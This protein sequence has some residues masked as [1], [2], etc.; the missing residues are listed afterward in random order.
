[1]ELPRKYPIYLILILIFFVSAYFVVPEAGSFI[2]GVLINMNQ[3][4]IWRSAR[5]ARSGNFA[6]YVSFLRERIPEDGRVV[7]PPEKVSNWALSNTPFMQFF[8]SPREVINCTTVECGSQFLGAEDTYLLIVGMDTF[9]GGGIQENE[10]HVRMLNDTWGVYGPEGGL[11]TGTDNNHRTIPNIFR[12]VLVP[13][14][15]FF[16]LILMG[17]VFARWIVPDYS[18]WFHIGVGYGLVIGVL[19]I[20]SYVTLLIL[21]EFPLQVLLLVYSIVLGLLFLFKI[22]PNDGNE[23]GLIWDSLLF[24]NNIWVLLFLGLSVVFFFIAVGS[25]YH[26]TDAIVLWGVKGEGIAQKG[27]TAV[28]EW[29]TNTTNYPLNIPLSIAALNKT[30]GTHLPTSKLLFPGFYLA[31][32][33]VLY[34]YLEDNLNTNLLGLGMLTFAMLPIMV[35]HARIG[36]A[37]LPLTYYLVTSGLFFSGL[38]RENIGNHTGQDQLLTAFFVVF[39]VWTRPEGVW[40]ILGISIVLILYGVIASRHSEIRKN[41]TCMVLPAILFWGFWRLTSMPF[42]VEDGAVSMVGDAFRSVSGGDFRFS[43]LLYILGYLGR[44]LINMRTWGGVGIGLV[45]GIL[46]F[47]VGKPALDEQIKTVFL[48]GMASVFLIIGMYYIFAFDTTHDISWWLN[49]G[50][51]RMIMPGMGLLWVGMMSLFSKDKG[52]NTVQKSI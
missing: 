40:F 41:L 52:R 8:L 25:G 48:S 16:Y 46:Y 18:L 6:D 2:K 44:Q 17:F 21:P 42:A 29:G 19:S 3:S 14:L 37:N 9:P 22:I 7:L 50:F 35:R 4:G 24:S 11:G 47:F 45:V 32:I 20:L 39:T 26:A 34:G 33:L 1:M 38:S 23:V 27:L 5:F 15:F 43:S 51:N 12:N 36:Y 10:S 13:I 30:F 49:S 31:L 28:N